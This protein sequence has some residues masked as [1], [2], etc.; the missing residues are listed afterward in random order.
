MTD[1]NQALAA[2]PGFHSDAPRGG[3]F[4]V[5]AIRRLSD[6]R[7][8]LLEQQPE[9]GLALAQ[10]PAQVLGAVVVDGTG[11]AAFETAPRSVVE[12]VH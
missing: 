6:H 5:T 11:G 2:E 10:G 1:G 8:E 7:P 12:F 9:N 3:G 4:E